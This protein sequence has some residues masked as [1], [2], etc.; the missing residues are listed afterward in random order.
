MY[1]QASLSAASKIAAIDREYKHK[2]DLIEKAKA[3]YTKKNLPPSSKT[4]GGGDST[5]PNL[6]IELKIR[7]AQRM[8]LLAPRNGFSELCALFRHC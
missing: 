1:H 2:Q 5:L 3:E 4:E 8:S 7:Y 6:I